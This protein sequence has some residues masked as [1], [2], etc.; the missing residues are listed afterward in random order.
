MSGLDCQV[1][2]PEQGLLLKRLEACEFV[3]RQI[4]EKRD[5][6]FTRWVDSKAIGVASVK[7]MKLN[8]HA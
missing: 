1:K 3:W 8:I 4:L 5:L 2:S 6:V 7:A